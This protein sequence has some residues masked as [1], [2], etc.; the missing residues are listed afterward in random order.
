MNSLSNSAGTTPEIRAETQIR[1]YKRAE[2][3]VFSKTK[4]GFGGLS[5]MAA[6]FPLRVNGVYIRTSEALYQ[7]CR[8]PHLPDVQRLIIA[9]ASPMTAKMQSKPF[10][11]DSRPDWQWVRIK[12]MRWCLRVKLAQ[13]SSDFSR[14]LLSTGD[15]PIVEESRKD[16]FW[17][18]KIVDADTLVGVNAL[19][20][21]LMELREEVKHSN[22]EQ[23][24]RVEPLPIADFLL[25]GKPIAV[26]EARPLRIAAEIHSIPTVE[27]EDTGLR[28]QLELD[29]V[30]R[31]AEQPKLFGGTSHQGARQ[32]KGGGL[33]GGIQPYPEYKE[34][35]LPWA[36]K[37]PASWSTERA[38]WLFT[39]MDRPVRPED[40]VVTCFR[41]G[42]VTLRKNRRLRG[43][44]E[45]IYE[46]GYQGIRKGDLVIHAM[47][48]FAGAVG[49]SDSDGKGT[50]VYAVCQPK[51]G[52]N[53]RYYAYVI[54]EMARSQW[55]L[56][57][58][59]GIR[60]RSTDFRYETFGR[61]RVPL[62]SSDDQAGI[63]TFLDH[64]NRRINRLIRAKKKV[65]ALLDEQKRSIIECSV[66]RGLHPSVAL[67]PSGVLWLGDIPKHWE[68]LR[69]KYVFREVDDRS[70]T[71]NEE[72]LSVSHIT[73]V[74][75]R[76]EKNITM[77]KASSYVGHKLCR[78]G[79]LVI[80]TM[81]AWMAAL[82]VST[83]T[84]IVSPG[85]AVYRPRLPK[86]VIGRYLDHLLRTKPYIG[87]YV[88]RST[89]IR[90]SRL[91]L[92]PEEFFKVP[93]ILPPS[94]EQREIANRIDDETAG[95]KAAISRAQQ[96]IDLIREY[97]TRL[98]ADVVTG[99][100]D[101]R[102]VAANLPSEPEV[103][104]APAE[105]GGFSREELEE[106]LDTEIAHE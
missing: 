42:T 92:Y 84:G 30:A 90:G 79:D 34:T 83:Y 100:L 26:I 75:P 7:A 23:L 87:N 55:I 10:R 18:A 94:E 54:G 73:G 51:N 96:E 53:A 57:L 40:D 103:I 88:C 82:G 64:V 70:T 11:K 44:T 31:R 35:E 28:H 45:A 17:G 33:I 32:A 3:A 41:D 61:Q 37:L 50:P 59:R 25:F 63:V 91:R 72:L 5:N 13:N 86:K 89:G 52:I 98:V 22:G 95:L 69:A 62:P 24:R 20:R 67:K 43:F 39:K 77:F 74:T 56:S 9:E 14:L 29:A 85:Y 4:E 106:T 68:V 49:V 19:G 47:D 46:S 16:E 65:I 8:F 27:Y 105:A 81:W 6:G 58:S 99:K 12:I 66:T 1:T 2:S 60:E 104:E 78:P 102:E 76:S 71:G 21:L 93:I 38:K 48:A 101:V 80:N 36:G 97:R 15:R